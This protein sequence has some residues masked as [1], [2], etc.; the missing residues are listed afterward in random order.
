MAK[1]RSTLK[2]ISISTGNSDATKKGI[3]AMPVLLSREHVFD[4]RKF[5]QHRKFRCCHRIF[6]WYHFSAA[7]LVRKAQRLVQSISDRKNRCPS[8][9]SSDAYAEMCPT[10]LNGQFK[11]E[12]YIYV[13]PRPFEECQRPYKHKR[14]K[15]HLQPSQ[16]FIVHHIGLSTLVRMLSACNRDQFLRE[17][18]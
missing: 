6:R 15:D 3:G 12:A 18:P 2:L 14:V 17:L 9:G 10:A 5:L 1:I 4:P 16:S 8:T 13:F 11:L 7:E